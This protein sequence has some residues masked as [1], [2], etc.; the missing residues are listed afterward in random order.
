MEEG[1]KKCRFA[2]FNYILKFS[3]S[4]KGTRNFLSVPLGQ[5]WKRDKWVDTVRSKCLKSSG[6]EPF[7]HA[8][9][10]KCDSLGLGALHILDTILKDK[11]SWELLFFKIIQWSIHELLWVFKDKH[12]PTLYFQL[13]KLPSSSR[14]QLECLFMPKD[15]GWSKKLIQ[16]VRF[17]FSC[18]LC[19]HS[20]T[21]HVLFVLFRKM[22]LMLFSLRGFPGNHGMFRILFLSSW[23]T[24]CQSYGIFHGLWRRKI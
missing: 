15:E 17:Y 16:Q 6:I 9:E 1:I 13:L 19:I 22:Y 23:N 4:T 7:Q 10:W 5:P 24:F 11:D 21:L 14:K 2:F 12:H 8:W 18:Y 20:S 3:F